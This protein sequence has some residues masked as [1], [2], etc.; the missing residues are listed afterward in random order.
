MQCLCVGIDSDKFHAMNPRLDHSLERVL[1][2]T[3]DSA[4]LNPGK[5][6]KLGLYLW[7]GLYQKHL[8]IIIK[9]K[10]AQAGL[11]ALLITCRQAKTPY[12]MKF[13]SQSLAFPNKP[14]ERLN[15]WFV[16]CLAPPNSCSIPHSARPTATT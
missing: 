3:S 15:V 11:K 10:Q 9:Q 7:H 12:G 6:F 2:G 13:F 14:P 8:R 5:C 16:F 4:D 1:A